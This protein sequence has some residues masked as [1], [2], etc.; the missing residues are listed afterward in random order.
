MRSHHMISHKVMHLWTYYKIK[1]GATQGNTKRTLRADV[2]IELDGGLTHG[3]VGVRAVINSMQI[4][5]Q[6]NSGGT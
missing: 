3:M 2:E 6:S 1:W 5:E 4:D